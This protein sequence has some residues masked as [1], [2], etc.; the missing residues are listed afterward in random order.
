MDAK[1][2]TVREKPLQR[3]GVAPRVT[4]AQF[5]KQVEQY[6]RL[7]GWGPVYHTRYSVGSAPGFPDLVATRAGRCCFLE[8]KVAGGR[9][10]P[11]QV[12]W[13]EALAGVGGTVEYHLLTPADWQFIEQTFR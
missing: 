2:A 11:A 8:L 4:E 13:G 3:A 1:R 7:M 12:E 5:Q 10:S 9:I 6:L